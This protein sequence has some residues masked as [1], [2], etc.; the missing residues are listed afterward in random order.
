MADY[1]AT[2]LEALRERAEVLVNSSKPADVELYHL[3]NNQLHKHVYQRAIQRPGVVVLHDAVMQH[4]YLGAL[5][6]SEYVAEF[7]HHYGEWARELGNELWKRRARSGVDAR[8][9]RYPMLG[10]IV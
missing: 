5:T 2:L 9:F 7:V 8:Y 3:G 10:R 6:E 1:G 4:F